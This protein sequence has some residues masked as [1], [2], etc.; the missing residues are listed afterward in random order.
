MLVGAHSR[1]GP[2]EVGHF[3]AQGQEQDENPSH[4]PGVPAL[5]LET[6]RQRVVQWTLS[7]DTS[8]LS[9]LACSCLADSAGL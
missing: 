2:D 9:Y 5:V 3:S 1:G 6:R 7:S 4:N 8:V